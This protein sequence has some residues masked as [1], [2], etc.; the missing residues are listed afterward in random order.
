MPATKQFSQLKFKMFDCL[1]VSLCTSGYFWKCS[2]GSLGLDSTYHQYWYQS[3]DLQKP[4]DPFRLPKRQSNQELCASGFLGS[5]GYELSDLPLRTRGS[6]IQIC[7]HQFSHCLASFMFFSVVSCHQ[8]TTGQ[9][10]I[11][12]TAMP[13]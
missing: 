7:Y 10:N 8:V 4:A 6:G 13:Q 2:G 9:N 11:F 5:T 12:T 1:L 3:H